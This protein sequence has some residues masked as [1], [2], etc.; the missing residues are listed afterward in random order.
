MAVMTCVDQDA[1]DRGVLQDRPRVAGA[2]GRVDFS[3]QGIRG[4]ACGGADTWKRDSAHGLQRR[5]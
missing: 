3:G 4:N 2:A 1:V 5:E